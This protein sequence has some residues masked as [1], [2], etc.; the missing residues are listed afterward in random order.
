MC[1]FRFQGGGLKAFRAFR[2]R[3][4]RESGVWLSSLAESANVSAASLPGMSEWPGHHFSRMSVPGGIRRIIWRMW[5]N[6]YCP[7]LGALGA[8]IRLRAA[9]LSDRRTMLVV[10]PLAIRSR[11]SSSPSSI[12]VASHSKFVAKLGLP[13]K[14]FLEY[15][16]SSVVAAALRPCSG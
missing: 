7:G 6:K 16:P 13:R 12:P 11:P 14:A 4:G 5:R 2:W 3:G 1:R 8:S 10:R 9:W 15:R